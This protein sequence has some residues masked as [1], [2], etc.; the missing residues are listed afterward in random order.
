MDFKV[1]EALSNYCTISRASELSGMKASR[2]MRRI[3]SGKIKAKKLGW[4]WIIPVSE[5]E[6]LKKEV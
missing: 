3:K 1:E 4:F 2:I 5:V 6:K